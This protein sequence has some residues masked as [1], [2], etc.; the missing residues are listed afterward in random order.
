MIQNVASAESAPNNKGDQNENLDTKKHEEDKK[1][2]NDKKK[3]KKDMRGL[4]D[5]PTE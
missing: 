4:D 5:L 3:Q 2:E 1:V